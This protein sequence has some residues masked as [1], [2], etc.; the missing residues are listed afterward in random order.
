MPLRGLSLSEFQVKLDFW[1]L[2]PNFLS[3][4]EVELPNFQLNSVPKDLYLSC[5]VA[6]TEPVIE[7]IFPIDKYSNIN[8][9]FRVTS[10][11]LKFVDKLQ[12][13]KLLS[14]VDYIHR[15]K[16]YWLKLEQLKF[17]SDEIELVKKPK[18]DVPLI[19]RNL[20]LFLDNHGI[21]RSRGRISKCKKLDFDAWNP[22]ILPRKSFLTE[23]FVW[24]THYP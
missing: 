17:Y 22:I 8:K 2:G 1:K 11:V 18:K 6:K 10:Y 7:S 19:V 5:N 21:L 14:N 9:V 4:K 13:R 20:N 15:P 3:Q 23:L 12:K 24:D 16:M